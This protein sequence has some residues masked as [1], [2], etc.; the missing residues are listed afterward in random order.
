M[1]DIYGYFYK[2]LIEFLGLL[3]LLKITAY[4]NQESLNVKEKRILSA[5]FKI[6][7]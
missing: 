5:V 3:L 1:S 2:E 6:L 4:I 7:L